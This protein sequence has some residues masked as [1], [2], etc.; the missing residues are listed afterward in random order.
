MKNYEKLYEKNFLERAD[1]FSE[2]TLLIELNIS[3]FESNFL[4]SKMWK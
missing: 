1:Y 2:N 4:H 3:K